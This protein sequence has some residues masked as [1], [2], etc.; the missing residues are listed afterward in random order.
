MD[1]SLDSDYEL[2]ELN[3]EDLEINEEDLQEVIPNVAAVPAVQPAACQAAMDQAVPIVPR[4]I[5]ARGTL[6]PIPDE[7][8]ALNLMVFDYLVRH[9]YKRSSQAFYEENPQEVN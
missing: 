9:G 6:H 7:R 3:G 5:E 2:D 8:I 4:R 1:I